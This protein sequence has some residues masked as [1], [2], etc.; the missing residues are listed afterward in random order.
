MNNLNLPQTPKRTNWSLRLFLTLIPIAAIYIIDRDSSILL[1][2]SGYELQVKL[3]LALLIGLIIAP[4][5]IKLLQII[6]SLFNGKWY[7]HKQQEKQQKQLYSGL[8]AYLEGDWHECVAQLK[9]INRKQDNIVTLIMGARAA[10]HLEKNELSNKWLEA[11]DQLTESHQLA[12]E[13]E[14][15]YQLVTTEQFDTADE[16][17]EKLS[18]EHHKRFEIIRYKHL[19]YKALGKEQELKRLEN[20]YASQLKKLFRKKHTS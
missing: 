17:L 15:L 12:P 16:M 8:L 11:S 20:K 13:L 9:P 19:V 4:W 1:T 3:W 14:R 7:R 18:A 10:F 6:I 2:L 5:L